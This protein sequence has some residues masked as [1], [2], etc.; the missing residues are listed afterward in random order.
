MDG[1]SELA[2]MKA[3]KAGRSEK[4][5]ALAG[6][7]ATAKTAASKSKVDADGHVDMAR[8]KG[9]MKKKRDSYAVPSPSE[10]KYPYGLSLHLDA[11]TM[12]K[13]GIEM[14]EAGDVVRFEGKAQVR[15][16]SKNTSISGD[17]SQSVDLQITA[18]KIEDTDT[19]DE[20]A[21]EDETDH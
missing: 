13:L 9:E 2:Q 3:K 6:M 4:E 15:S 7:G 12:E 10:E 18:L 17:Q 19:A 11:D 14:P 21:S 20:G 8:T 1:K 5:Q 16:T